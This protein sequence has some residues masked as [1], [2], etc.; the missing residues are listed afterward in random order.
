MIIGLAATRVDNIFINQDQDWIGTTKFDQPALPLAD[1]D[2][3]LH[4][5]QQVRC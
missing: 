4:A 5:Y 3:I 1:R 2:Y